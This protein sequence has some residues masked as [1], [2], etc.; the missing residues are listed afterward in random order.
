[1][2]KKVFNNPKKL[3]KVTFILLLVAIYPFILN[4]LESNYNDFRIY[5]IIEFIFQ[6][7]IN[8]LLIAL[9]YFSKIKFSKK[10]NLKLLNNLMFIN[11]LIVMIF[12]LI[13][14]GISLY[15]IYIAIV[16]NLMVLLYFKNKKIYRPNIL[17]WI[18]IVCYIVSF[19]IS[20]INFQYLL[21]EDTMRIYLLKILSTIYIIPML[22][23]FR[24]YGFNK[25]EKRKENE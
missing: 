8:G 17:F 6:Y 23:Y 18:S 9:Y 1:M 21:F 10:I 2:I 11:F 22:G 4:S 20:I 19:I 25:I 12:E 13:K 3:V 14:I 7:L 5:F 24:L 15:L 16:I